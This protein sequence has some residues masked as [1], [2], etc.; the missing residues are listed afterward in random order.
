MTVM[1]VAML[2]CC[3]HK[4]G[5]TKCVERQCFRT[6]CSRARIGVWH[7]G[8]HTR[9]FVKIRRS[10]LCCWL[11]SQAGRS[12]AVV[13]LPRRPSS[14]SKQECQPVSKAERHGRKVER[15]GRDPFAAEP[16]TRCCAAV[17]QWGAAGP[18]GTMKTWKHGDISLAGRA[19][20]L[21]IWSVLRRDATQ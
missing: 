8:W 21:T 17:G 1:P 20:R 16:Q 10:L 3:K 14:E 7:C 2:H 4:S 12:G 13:E 15:S 6:R 9:E 5:V 11:L 19:D 18:W